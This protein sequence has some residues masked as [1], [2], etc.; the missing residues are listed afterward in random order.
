MKKIKNKIKSKV[1]Q[2]RV[3]MFQHFYFLLMK[4]KQEDDKMSLSRNIST[5]SVS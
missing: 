1:K 3:E 2:I 5:I 4:K